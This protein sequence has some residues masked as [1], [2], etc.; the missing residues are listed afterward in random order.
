MLDWCVNIS[1]LHAAALADLACSVYGSHSRG[2]SLACKTY[3]Q[4]VD[5][6]LIVLGLG[7]SHNVLGRRGDASA[8]LRVRRTLAFLSPAVLLTR[9]MQGA[10]TDLPVTRRRLLFL[11]KRL[12]ITTCTRVLTLTRLTDYFVGQA[13]R[14]PSTLPLARA[15]RISN[16]PATKSKSTPPGPPSLIESD[17][18]SFVL[19]RHRLKSPVQQ[20]CPLPAPRCVAWDRVQVR[21]CLL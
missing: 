13:T 19:F 9:Q 1:I 18:F 11:E 7:L 20:R 15:L 8:C 3:V 21:F 6:V 12:R 5:H 16:Q 2:A 14:S 10:E 4:R 17:T